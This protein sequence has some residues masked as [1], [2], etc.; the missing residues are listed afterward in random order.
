MSYS[1][2]DVIDRLPYELQARLEA[3]EFFADI[4]VIVADKG[5]VKAELERKQAAIT[6]KAGRRGVAVI[7]LQ[8]V[9]EDDYPEVNFGPLK[10]RPAFQVVEHVELNNDERGTKKSARRV[11]R[12]IHQVIKPLALYGIVTQFKADSPAI[13]PVSVSDLGDQVVA[14]QANFVTYE[15]D[16]EQLSQVATP[17]FS[18]V[19]QT[20]VMTSA[21]EGA[22][23]WYSVDDSFPAPNKPGSIEY[24]VPIAIPEA[25]FTVRAAAYKAGSIASE[26][27]RGTIEVEIVEP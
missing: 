4:P 14:M 2:L 3:D 19:A 10:L 25:G 27:M 21:T 16:A 11:T 9:A 18:A 15:F 26:V 6:E 12:R 1:A 22:S 5:N 17:E 13:E 24:T 8:I 20:L 23:I 7:V